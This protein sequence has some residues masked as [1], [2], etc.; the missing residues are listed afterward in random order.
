[1]KK[2]ILIVVIVIAL[3]P[4]IVHL[5][6]KPFDPEAFLKAVGADGF[7]LTHVTD[8]DHPDLGSIRQITFQVNGDFVNLY[9]FDDPGK[10]NVQMTMQQPDPEESFVKKMH[11]RK[12][13]GAA[14]DPNKKVTVVRNGMWMLVIMSDNE[15]MTND[16]V[17][18]FKKQ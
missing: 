14:P 12:A 7:Q 8:R 3:L 4:L 16:V 1:M 18:E 9:H 10:L 2:A 15:P 17:K 5:K 6:P 13:L 11:L